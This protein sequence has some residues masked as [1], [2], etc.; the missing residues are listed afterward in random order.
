MTGAGLV[1]CALA[2]RTQAQEAGSE[3]AR[4]NFVVIFTDDQTYSAIG[5]NNPDVKTPHL[6]KLASRGIIFNKAFVAS[7]ICAASRASMM[8]GVFPQ[9]HGVIALDSKRFSQYRS[10]GA[11]EHYTL[12]RQLQA[13]GYHCAFWGK[14]HIGDPLEY[15]FSEGRETGPYD[16]TV[17]FR[18]A[19]QFLARA[20]ADPRPFFLWVAP[21]Q[22]HVPLKPGD[23]WLELYDE[24][25]F[26]LSANFREAP[27][28]ESINNQG[29]PGELFY[30]DSD[31]TQNWQNLPA[32]PPRDEDIIRR[33]MK[34]YY[35]TI[36]HLD[37]QVGRL[38]S[39]LETSRLA[40]DTV[41]IFLSDN[42][43]HLGN[44][45][46][47]NKITMHEESVR[48]PMFITGPRF[49]YPGMKSDALVSSLDVY[50]TVLELAGIEPPPH[51]MGRS[52]VPL[53]EKPSASFREVVFSECTGVGGKPG[54]GHRMARGP[55]WKYVLTDT[56]EEYLFDEQKDFDELKNVIGVDDAD[57]KTVL[58]KLRP[59]L[60][61][62]MKTIG[63]RTAKSPR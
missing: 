36:S 24:N 51:L 62:W 40:E 12:G 6:D 20:A 21:R 19:E 16:D 53:I 44:H 14:S 10:G 7:P 3:A 55:R 22:P 15:G 2:A 18:E 9:Q 41:I 26:R 46:L 8:S 11:R 1:G 37:D 42:G 32:G 52:L 43:Y 63:D 4:P 48:V 39:R 17:T 34:A 30:R 25:K 60:I 31:Y 33:F 61:D 13:A 28:D 5:Y 50:P 59:A 54:D 29:V 27:F 49:G 38:V 23:R 56:D 45:G 47:G 35:A 57:T 58:A